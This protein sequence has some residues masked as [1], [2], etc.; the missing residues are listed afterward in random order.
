[1][2]STSKYLFLIMEALYLPNEGGIKTT[3]FGGCGVEVPIPR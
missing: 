3:F 2:G 1:M